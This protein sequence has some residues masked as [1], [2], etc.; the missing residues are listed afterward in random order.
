MRW[1]L[2]EKIWLKTFENKKGKNKTAK[3]RN[4]KTEPCKAVKPRSQ[5]WEPQ[6]CWYWKV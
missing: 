2:F 5:I 4:C 6:I 3:L 1:K